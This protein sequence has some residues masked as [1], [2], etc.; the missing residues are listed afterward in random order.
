MRFERVDWLSVSIRGGISSSL[1]VAPSLRGEN[2][3]LFPRV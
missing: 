2:L 1:N 3:F